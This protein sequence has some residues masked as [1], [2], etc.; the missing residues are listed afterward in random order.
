VIAKSIRS[1]W[2]ERGDKRAFELLVEKYRKLGRHVA[3][4]ARPAK[5]R[6]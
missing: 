6:M 3:A 4:G 1:S 2:S 5:W